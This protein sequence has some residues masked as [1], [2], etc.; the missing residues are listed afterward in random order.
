MKK[1][2]MITAVLLAMGMGNA[3]ADETR[4][5]IGLTGGFAKQDGDYGRRGDN[6]RGFAASGGSIGAVARVTQHLNN[7]VFFGAQ[8]AIAFDFSDDT[9]MDP[10]RVDDAGRVQY[11]D[12]K[13]ESKYNGDLM[14]RLG[15]RFGNFSPY[16][17]GG[18]SINNTELMLTEARNGGLG[19]RTEANTYLGWKVAVGA[20]ANIT[21]NI[22]FFVQAAYAD[23]GTKDITALMP[24]RNQTINLEAEIST[25]EAKAGIMYEF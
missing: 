10:E 12:L 1:S 9:N 18:I 14:A 4:L 17:A 22:L 16:V 15:M 24:V 5:A 6:K 7:G 11:V 2:V 20:D 21:D 3:H 23:Y 13:M 25:A 19:S 8:A